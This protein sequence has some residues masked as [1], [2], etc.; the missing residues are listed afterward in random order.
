MEGGMN[1]R[2]RMMLDI[3]KKGR[4]QYGYVACKAEYEAEGTRLDELLRLVEICRRADLKLGLKVGGCEAMRD[5]MEAKQIGVD[6][7]IAPMV[8]T[9][10][11]LSKYIEA[12]NKIYAPEERGDVTFLY[13]IETFTG[14]QNREEMIKLGAGKDGVQGA[15]FGRVDYSG[16]K[17]LGR[18]GVNSDSVAD[19]VIEV[20]RLCKASG[21]ELVM[22]GG[23]SMDALGVVRRVQASYLTRFET[24]K[25]IYDAGAVA[26]T[27][28]E[29]GLLQ[30]VHFELLWLLN[31]RDYYGVIQAEDAERI[32]MLESRWNVL[33]STATKASA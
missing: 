6:Y 11:A 4:D 7:I 21:Q 29:D 28:I 10:Y 25:I 13:N 31:K 14:F 23:I 30:A 3:L 24:R 15:V 19:D 26:R 2:E 8:E 12:K 17:G 22:G 18:A 9:P 20:G 33:Q 5:M 1:N 16:S 27:G 32:E